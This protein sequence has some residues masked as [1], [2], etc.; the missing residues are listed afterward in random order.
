MKVLA[1]DFGAS[2]GRG[3]VYELKDGKLYQDEIHRFDNDPVLVG[4]RFYWDIL[5]LFAEIKNG[6][7]KCTNRGIDIAAIGIDTWGVDYGLLDAEGRL[8]S[9][10]YHYRDTRTES[11]QFSE[12]DKRMIYERTGIQFLNFNTLLQ[13]IADKREAADKIAKTALFIPDLFNYF[14]TGVMRT[15]YTIASTSQMLGAQ[16]RT[17][18]KELLKHFGIADIF[19]PMIEPGE[20]VGYLSD[21]ICEELGCKKVPVVT[22][23][24][25]DTGSAVVSVPM[26]NPEKS[27][28]ISCGTWLLFGSEERAPIVTDKC[29]EYNYTNEGG[30]FDTYRFLHNIMGLWIQQES[31]RAF[32]RA[33]VEVSYQDMEDEAETCTPFACFID[34]DDPSFAPPGNMPKRIAEF[35]VRTGQ[36]APKTP[37]EVNRCVMESLALQCKKAVD[38]MEQITGR[39]V[40]TINMVGG[41]IKNDMLCRFVA[42][43]TGK[44]VVAGPIEATSIG[45]ALMQFVALGEI[46]DLAQARQVV[47][48]SFPCKEYVPADE[49]AWKQAYQRFCEIVELRKK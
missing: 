22:V 45:N 26:D 25:H 5:R 2:G 32:K 48:N 7:L 33:G 37:G 19:A 44:R 13:R 41:G 10:P 16:S 35:A 36:P 30:V 31:R 23:A 47:R 34:P 39:S 17:F 38:E 3:I 27:V 28:Y 40:D 24:S 46:K 8:L 21:A 43:A 15:E 18:D 29:Y 11:V 12:A 42:N 49:E 20:V 1:F 4:G 6:I 9:N 14:L